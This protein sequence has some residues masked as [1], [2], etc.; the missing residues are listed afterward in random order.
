MK[1]LGLPT[2][3]WNKQQHFITWTH[4]QSN[5]LTWLKQSANFSNFLV[6]SMDFSCTMC[7]YQNLRDFFPLPQKAF[8]WLQERVIHQNSPKKSQSTGF[9]RKILSGMLK[10]SRIFQSCKL[11]ITW[12][13]KNLKPVLSDP[14]LQF[15]I[16]TMIPASLVV[17]FNYL[18]LISPKEDN[19]L[20]L[21]CQP[22]LGPERFHCWV[23]PESLL[24]AAEHCS[25]REG[26]C[27]RHRGQPEI[28]WE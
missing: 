7:R 11:Q 12:R 26:R 8:K 23:F 27:H 25:I 20:Q 5:A 24:E 19:S 13:E 14:L 16:P 4:T 3:A 1:I 18:S 6:H 9:G 15:L 10:D 2:P 28:T 22:G 21:Q 17:K